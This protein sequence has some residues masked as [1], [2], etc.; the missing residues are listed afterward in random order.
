MDIISDVED[1]P[2]DAPSLFLWRFPPSSD[3]WVQLIFWLQRS[4]EEELADL[5]KA[6]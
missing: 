2:L 1:M 3:E 4:R 5:R 6:E